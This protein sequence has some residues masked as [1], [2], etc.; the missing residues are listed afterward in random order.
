MNSSKD[1]T[2]RNRR[3]GDADVSSASLDAVP[4]PPLSYHEITSEKH[5]ATELKVA[6]NEDQ[7]SD[8]TSNNDILCT[9]I[10]DSPINIHSPKAIKQGVATASCPPHRT[11]ASKPRCINATQTE[12]DPMNNSLTSPQTPLN[13]ASPELVAYIKSTERELEMLLKETLASPSNSK[14]NSSMDISLDSSLNE[15]MRNISF[16]EH[17]VDEIV[18]T[19][20]SA[21]QMVTKSVERELEM[22]LKET[23]A[24]PSN[25]K[26]NS[27]MDIS[28]DS[29]LNE[30]KRDMSFWEHDVDDIVVNDA[31]A[32]QV[33]TKSVQIREPECT[34]SPKKKTVYR[35]GTEQVVKTEK[36][37]ER[38]IINHKSQ[39]KRRNVDPTDKQSKDAMKFLVKAFLLSCILATSLAILLGCIY[40]SSP[41]LSSSPLESCQSKTIEGECIARYHSSY[42]AIQRFQLGLAT[43]SFGFA[44]SIRT[45]ISAPLQRLDDKLKS[46]QINVHVLSRLLNVYNGLADIM[47]ECSYDVWEYTAMFNN[48]L[49]VGSV[50]SSFQSPPELDLD[51]RIP[52]NAHT[53]KIYVL[54]RR[55]DMTADRGC[56][57]RDVIT[58]ELLMEYATTHIDPDFNLATHPIILRNLWPKESFDGNERRLTPSGILNDPQLSNFILPNYFG[59]ATKTGYD[60]LVP[61][62]DRTLLSEFVKNIMTGK[63]PYAKI[64][65]QSIVEEHP[66][67]R[68]EIV[69]LKLA[70]DLFRWDPIVDDLR[71][72]ALDL[73]WP[74]FKPLVR[75]L[76]PS[77][78]YPI[79]IAG[80]SQPQ[81]EGSHS[82]TDLHSEPIGN[83]A[84]QLHGTR[85]WTLVPSKWS[86]LLRPTV[87]KHGRG[88]FSSLATIASQRSIFSF[89]CHLSY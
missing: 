6:A 44:T 38:E 78:Y 18:S 30:L 82:R 46:R 29:S 73:V 20:A 68:E 14:R 32:V 9:A 36:L 15:L 19:D 49:K 12:P 60:A 72:I 34:E 5:S 4:S 3:I 89:Q 26:R 86:G 8:P 85:H 11:P 39:T 80:L 61:D 10:S 13:I 22:L 48:A 50:Q 83:I 35:R 21:V 41:L 37:R 64:G 47:E 79:F 74:A 69:P 7:L 88:K 31:S 57:L 25:N 58:L 23:L 1:D 45:I 16:Q 2:A 56:T 40:P 51:M 87:S 62:S 63:T 81:R 43:I 70:K 28:L 65:T 53:A 77:T 27:S 17:D 55:S 76:P 75:M 71:N 59:D 54:Q 52:C 24:S 84:A 66:E 67:L 33:M 42:S